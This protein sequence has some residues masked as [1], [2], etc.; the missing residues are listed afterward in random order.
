MLR[1]TVYTFV[2]QGFFLMQ[3]KMQTPN[4]V[5]IITNETT[6]AM[7]NAIPTISPLDN[8]STVDIICCSA[9]V[10]SL[11]CVVGNSV[12]VIFVVRSVACI[13]GNSAV[14]VIVFFV[15]ESVACVVD[16]PVVE[17]FACAVGGS[18]L[19]STV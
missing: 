6:A 1:A 19:S 5:I 4:I 15:V 18:V 16:N 8:A 10:E 3:Q 17:S 9:V 13:A 12:V 11:V 7:A 2:W 14:V